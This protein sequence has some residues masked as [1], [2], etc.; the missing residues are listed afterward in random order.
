MKKLLLIALMAVLS[1]TAVACGGNGE[2]PAGTETDTEAVTVTESVTEGET[3]AETVPETLPETAPETLPENETETKEETK[4]ETEEETEQQTA[5]ETKPE[6]PPETK[7]EVPVGPT[8]ESGDNVALNKYVQASGSAWDGDMWGIPM[9]TDGSIMQTEFE[10]GGT[11]GWMSN[12]VTSVTDTTWI[13]IDLGW[14]Y[15]INKIVLYPRQSGERFPTGFYVEVSTDGS[16]WTKVI[17]ETA[18]PY[19]LEGRVYEFDTVNAAYVRL[20]TTEMHVDSYVEAFGG[21]IAQL[22]E[23]EVYAS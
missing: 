19:T 22:S 1:L 13:S 10:E 21:Y 20:V 3:V 5:A 7:P 9:V 11:N 12:A 4:E 14:E 18:D 2:S 8:W 6:P 16:T 17:E 15:P 23:I